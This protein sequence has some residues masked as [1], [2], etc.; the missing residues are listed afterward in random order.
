[1]I[2]VIRYGAG[3]V[4]SIMNALFKIGADARLTADKDEIERASHVIFP[5]VGEASSAMADLEKS[6][7]K[8]VIR[9]LKRPFLGICL[10]MQLMCSFSEEGDVPCLGIFPERVKLFPK[11][12]GYKIPHVGWNT[13]E[14]TSG[15]LFAP[16]S[17]EEYV[18][19]V[20]SYYVPYSENTSAST[21][22]DGLCFSSALEKGNFYGVQFHPEKSA[23]AGLGILRRFIE[24]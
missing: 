14:N 18:Y 13:L 6:G 7:L 11:D 2:A 12:R 24:L 20:H 4:T 3:N 10:G 22:Y 9:S 8:D 19:F 21:R 16:T 1:M 17:D 5:G 23:D 15:R